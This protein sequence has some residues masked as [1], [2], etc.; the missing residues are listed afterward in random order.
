MVKSKQTR[1]AMGLEQ[2]E[3]S[4]ESIIGRLLIDVK[5]A[6][7]LPF[8]ELL[9][10][11][12]IEYIDT[13]EDLFIELAITVNALR[14][15]N[16][17]VVQEPINIGILKAKK[18]R[19]EKALREEQWD[20]VAEIDTS[21]DNILEYSPDWEELKVISDED[22]TLEEKAA[23]FE[24]KKN[25]DKVAGTCLDDEGCSGGVCK[26]KGKS[27]KIEVS[28]KEALQISP[29]ATFK[30]I[31]DAEGHAI[32][33]TDDAKKE[34]LELYIGKINAQIQTR[35][36]KLGQIKRKKPFTH[37]LIDPQSLL[38]VVAALNPAGNHNPG[39]RNTFQSAMS[40]QALSNMPIAWM[41]GSEGAIKTLLHPTRPI[42][43]PMM[44]K[45]LG[46]NKYPTGRMVSVMFST[47][48]GFGIEDGFL[49]NADSIKRGLFR[50]EVRKTYSETAGVSNS[51]NDVFTVPRD[52]SE[53][54][55]KT[56]YRNIGPD[57]L[58]AIGS[59]LVYGDVIISKVR[60]AGNIETPKPVTLMYGEYG[61]VKNVKTS[62]ASGKITVH[63]ELAVTRWPIV[64]DK[65]EA[66]YSQ[67][68]TI[69]LV[70]ASNEMPYDENGWR[71]DM[72]INPHAFTSRMT[73]GYLIEIIA[74]MAGVI[75]GR[76]VDATPFSKIDVTSYASTLRD[77]GFNPGSMK[78]M[79]S[80]IT[81][82]LLEAEIYTGFCYFQAL[83]HHVADKAR[84][85]GFGPINPVTGQAVKNRVY[86]GG[87]KFGEMESHA[88]YA[89]GAT[90]ILQERMKKAAD[91]V[92]ILICNKCGTTSYYNVKNDAVKEC[93]VCGYR[94]F[95]LTSVPMSMLISES[96]LNI[97]GVRLSYKTSTDD[98]KYLS[99][100]EGVKDIDMDE[101]EDYEEDEDEELEEDDEDDGDFL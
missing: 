23:F 98:Y 39:P 15:Y 7:H 96:I 12:Y 53:K 73:A 67:K 52:L 83:C 57:G 82:E 88:V 51:Y 65:F 49:M 48:T 44:Y 26:Q 24:H 2:Y 37:C 66:R 34:A 101:D 29:A 42:F 77:Y 92:E 46:M 38:G 36:V 72:V 71:P 9:H 3:D 60:R 43:E 21:G 94:S 4:P 40:K 50:I 61:Y 75:T 80:G 56:I 6:W 70:V 87:I 78:R 45:T 33:M 62:C 14:N 69:G 95:G 93:E 1:E 22:M 8:A 10:N 86:Q 84:A 81:N 90:A 32:V 85:R 19:Y 89:H 35:G 59:Y 63:V 25:K 20:I 13:Y 54:Q 47:T 30:T 41:E 58:P 68:G 97:T 99:S 11:G 55:R 5:D 27:V 18:R 91:E 76:R 74:S 64:G 31:T 79:R 17:Y 16:T 28:N 100:D